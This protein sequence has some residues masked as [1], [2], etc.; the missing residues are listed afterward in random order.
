MDVHHK[1]KK[2][3]LIIRDFNGDGDLKMIERLERKCEIGS[4]KGLSILTNMMGDP[5][6]RIRL[7][8]NHVMMVAELAQ[9]KEIV[10]VVGGCM[11]CVGNGLGSSNMNMGCILGLRVSPRHRRMG[12]GL[13]LVK[14]VEEW[15]MRNGA[16]YIYLATEE[17][18][19]ASTNL[20]FLKR[21]Y[22]KLTSLAILVQPIISPPNHP[23][24]DIRIEKLSI[25]QAMALYRDRVGSN[26]DFFPADMDAILREKLSMG[27]WVSF[28]REEEWLGLHCKG[29]SEQFT[30][31]TPSSWAVL[32]IWKTYEAYK[33]E[34]RAKNP[35]GF[36]CNRL[37]NAGA[38]AFPPC[39]E[40]PMFC[41][42][43]HKPF[44]FLFVY[45]VHGEG[46]RVG[47]LLRSLWGF[48]CNMGLKV[49][50]CK[51]LVTELAV[52]DP[53]L[54]HMPQGPSISLLD[55][56]WC[57]K[58]VDGNMDGQDRW[59]DPQSV[60]NVLVDPRDF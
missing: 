42:L 8:Q 55:D 15:A 22:K 53:L 45:G 60:A 51:V 54:G 2:K 1:N 25:E 32:S 47:E 56:L 26:K 28:F 30:S 59:T 10:G 9:S 36:F 18:N 3:A 21:N 19:V 46:E 13:K 38:K 34:I 11:K 49:K 40:V 23:P 4:K 31:R 14:S 43:P 39:L 17:T 33:L 41:G 29:R 52:S 12:I 57:F 27:T 37:C 16:Q 24:H 20:F 7:Y 5:Q 58:R 6:C 50:G 48:A 35:F 44:G